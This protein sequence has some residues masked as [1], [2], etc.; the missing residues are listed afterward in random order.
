[1]R[2]IF[3]KKVL[4]MIFATATLLSG[5][6]SSDQQ[7]TEEPV[8]QG[9]QNAQS[10]ADAPQG[11]DANQG[12]GNSAENAV[13]G[14]EAEGNNIASAEAASAEPPAGE[15]SDAPTETAPIEAAPMEAAP[16]PAPLAPGAPA[17]TASPAPPSA[18]VGGDE[19]APQPNRFVRYIQVASAAVHAE[20]Q[21]SAPTVVTL[22][23]GDHVLVSEENGWGKIANGKYIKLSDLSQKAIARDRATL[24]WN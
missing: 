13:A 11:E 9:N 4:P 20:P 7:E 6:C 21:D 3:V 1:M 2:S 18:P 15:E 10:N 22:A 14:S 17:S 12:E 23:K 8:S 5:A 19:V 16:P 24:T